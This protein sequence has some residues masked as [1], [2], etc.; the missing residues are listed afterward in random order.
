MDFGLDDFINNFSEEIKQEVEKVTNSLR[1]HEFISLGSTK[2]DFSDKDIIDL[3][4]ENNKNELISEIQSI[5]RKKEENNNIVNEE[6]N[7]VNI[8][9]IGKI[10]ELEIFFTRILQKY[11]P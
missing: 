6:N 8:Y 2:P 1:N 9:E 4:D 5:S 3:T 7:D 11:K 10:D